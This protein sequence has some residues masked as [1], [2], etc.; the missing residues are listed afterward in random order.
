MELEVLKSK[1]HNAFVTETSIDSAESITIDEDLMDAV[2]MIEGELVHVVS[3]RNGE[4][5]ITQVG[6]GKRGSRSIGINGTAALKI[7][8]GDKIIVIAYTAMPEDAALQFRPK[9]IFPRHDNSF[10]S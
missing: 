10:Q 8:K 5:I 4:R 9:I 6:K 7:G 3:H 2:G 1:I